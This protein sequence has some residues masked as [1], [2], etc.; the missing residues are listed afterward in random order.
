MSI[1]FE[2][3]KFVNWNLEKG[4][5]SCRTKKITGT[6]LLPQ[7][8]TDVFTSTLASS[9]VDPSIPFSVYWILLLPEYVSLWLSRETKL[10]IWFSWETLI[11]SDRLNKI[12]A[13]NIFFFIH[14]WINVT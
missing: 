4:H 12:N 9:R 3:K 6:L 2:K 14:G 13:Q 7:P 5:M 1:N 11:T 8:K 10:I